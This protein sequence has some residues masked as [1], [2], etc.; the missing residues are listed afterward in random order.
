M[1]NARCMQHENVE[2]PHC[3]SKT[4]LSGYS[5]SH[6]TAHIQYIMHAVCESCAYRVR[7]TTLDLSLDPMD[8]LA[9]LSLLKRV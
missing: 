3:T 5:L 6:F 8:D 4:R 1:T 7:G 2:L 9:Y